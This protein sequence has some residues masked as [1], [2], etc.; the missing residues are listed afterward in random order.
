MKQ[1]IL[2]GSLRPFLYPI[3]APLMPPL[4]QAAV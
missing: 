3:A 4:L 1:K 2:A